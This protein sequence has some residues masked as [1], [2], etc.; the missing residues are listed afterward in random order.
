[1]KAVAYARVSSKEQEKE[2]Y[3]IPSQLRLLKEYAHKIP[4]GSFV[5]TLEKDKL[6]LKY[7]AHRLT[8][9][10]SPEGMAILSGSG[11]VYL[12]E[13]RRTGTTLTGKLYGRTRRGL[14]VREVTLNKCR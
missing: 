13:L 2:G 1:M 4:P 12:A 10:V 3:S 11:N 14:V 5:V 7:H 6:N 8:G 9:D